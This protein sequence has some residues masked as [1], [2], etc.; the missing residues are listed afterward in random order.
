MSIVDP[1]VGERGPLTQ[2]TTGVVAASWA[3]FAGITLLMLGN[4]LQVSLLGIRSQLEG[5]SVV[6]SGAIMA[7]YFVGFLVGSRAAAKALASVGHIRVFAALASMASSAA[8]VHGLIVHPL[9]WLLMR[10]TTG[11][12]MAGLYVVV[13]SWINDLATNATRGRLL[14]LYMVVSM[15]GLAGGQF[16]LN[17]ADP[18]SAQ[19]FIIASVLISLAL[20]P[21]SLSG[22]GAPPTTVPEPMS[23]IQLIRSVPTGPAVSAMVGVAHGSLL[24]MGALYATRAGMSPA[25]TAVFMFAPMAGGVVLQL[26]IGLL[27]DRVSRRVVMLGVSIGAAGMAALLLVVPAGGPTAM[28]LMFLVGGFSF[29]LYSLGIAYTNDWIRP[30]QA[31]G[32]SA[33]LVTINGLGAI[34]GPL[35]AA[36]LIT[37]FGTRMFFV[38][39]VLA[40]GAIALYLGYRVAFRAGIPLSGQGRFRPVPA[41]ASATVVA[42][43]ARRNRQGA[44]TAEEPQPT[45]VGPAQVR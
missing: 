31:M 45:E 42:L 27:S 7:S 1:P 25:R 18:R 4:G 32:A 3:L 36:A 29:P 11:A 26:P 33:S 30:E 20:V 44:G 34:A 37:G 15:G 12:C 38:A 17:L 43:L 14:A 16:L 8:L 24:G 40:H 6:V 10:F 19:L 35:V 21:V 22:R 2:P 41:R 39:L 23:L 13:E 5:F 28:V 9:P